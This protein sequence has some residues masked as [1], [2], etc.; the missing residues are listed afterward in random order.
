LWTVSTDCSSDWNSDRVE[1]DDND[2]DD[3]GGGGGGGDDS[4]DDDNDDDVPSSTPALNLNSGYPIY[5]DRFRN[6]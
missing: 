2:D 1:D 3:G 6:M 4:D 5:L